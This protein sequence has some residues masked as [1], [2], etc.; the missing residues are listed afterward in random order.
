MAAELLHS[1]VKKESDNNT[2]RALPGTV[3]FFK[4]TANDPP[5]FDTGAR[6]LRHSI[7]DMLRTR[8]KLC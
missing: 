6:C 8:C 5:T 7:A 3:K 1:Y 4:R 2:R